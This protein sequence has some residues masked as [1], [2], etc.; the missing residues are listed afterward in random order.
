MFMLSELFE[1]IE[2]DRKKR[3]RET[4][5]YAFVYETSSSGKLKLC[6]KGAYSD[7]N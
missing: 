1:S 3:R 4:V 7:W 5:H 2:D 6:E